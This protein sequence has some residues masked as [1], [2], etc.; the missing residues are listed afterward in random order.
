MDIANGPDVQGANGAS[1]ISDASAREKKLPDPLRS[2]FFGQSGGQAAVLLGALSRKEFSM[3]PLPI[4]LD[5]S[6]SIDLAIACC[7]C[8]R[9]DLRGTTHS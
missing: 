5:N 9:D 8:G 6:G 1:D 2:P 7:I 4:R 3:S